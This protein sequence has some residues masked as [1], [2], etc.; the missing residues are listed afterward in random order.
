MEKENINLEKNKEK[1]LYFDDAFFFWSFWT[2]FLY[3]IIFNVFLY[4]GLIFSSFTLILQIDRCHYIMIIIF[5]FFVYIFIKQNQS[6]L[7]I[8]ERNISKPRVNVAY[9]LTPKAKNV[10]IETQKL[11]LIMICHW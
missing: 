8:T 1:S 10:L 4:L 2:R 11:L 5:L 3:R 9:F 6:A 7:L